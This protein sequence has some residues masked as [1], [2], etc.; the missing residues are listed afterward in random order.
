[1]KQHFV[2]FTLLSLSKNTPSGMFTDT[3][4]QV[5]AVRVP[6]HPDFPC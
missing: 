6:G 5:L 3:L 1:M 2:G 4:L